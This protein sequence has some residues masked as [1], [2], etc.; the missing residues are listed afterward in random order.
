MYGETIALK[1]GSLRIQTLKSILQTT[2]L[3]WYLV[4][5]NSPENFL[6]SL[7]F[8]IQIL[9]VIIHFSFGRTF[10]PHYKQTWLD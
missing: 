8:I 3:K 7:K 6:V 5:R 4:S 9:I 1:Q 2:K 10:L